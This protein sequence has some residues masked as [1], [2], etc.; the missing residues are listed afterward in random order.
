LLDLHV[1]KENV[2][3]MS[4]IGWGDVGGGGGGGGVLFT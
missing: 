2:G 3:R 4:D 1:F